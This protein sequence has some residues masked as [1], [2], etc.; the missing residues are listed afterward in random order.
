MQR[1]G[2]SSFFFFVP[3]VVETAAGKLVNCHGGVLVDVT[4]HKIYNQET[5]V[6]AVVLFNADVNPDLPYDRF[7]NFAHA[8]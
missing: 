2:V 4:H 6:E 8:D 5:N 7:S 1:G 3:M